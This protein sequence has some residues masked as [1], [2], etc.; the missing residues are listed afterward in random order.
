[1]P[2]IS[3]QFL[4][5]IKKMEGEIIGSSL[6]TD[7]DFIIEKEGVKG[8]KKLETEMGKLGYPL[9]Q[10]EIDKYKWYPVQQDFLSLLLT[11]K[12]FNWSDETIRE[13]GRWGAKTNFIIKL[14]ARLVSKETISKLASKYW[15]KYYTRGEIEY[16]L[17]YKKRIGI[18]T[19]RD[20]I[21]YPVHLHFLEGYFYQIMSLIVP[22]ENLKVEGR[23]TKE[24]NVHQFK[25]TW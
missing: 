4:E 15:R 16:K 17:D 1:M 3:K 11:Q 8:L 23:E 12:I 22:S 21:I 19:I 5:E 18:V 6:K 13:W 25:I 24:F 2:L 9:K 10:A 14:M 7:R 20:F